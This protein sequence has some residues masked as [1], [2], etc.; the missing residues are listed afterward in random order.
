M[1]SLDLLGPHK[2]GHDELLPYVRRFM[3]AVYTFPQYLS[4]KAPP[5]GSGDGTAVEEKE[6]RD[7]LRSPSRP[8]ARDEAQVFFRST[9][10]KR[11]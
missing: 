1:L 8:E 3:V 6:A 9:S 4:D 5:A 7:E 2:R 10:P 11:G